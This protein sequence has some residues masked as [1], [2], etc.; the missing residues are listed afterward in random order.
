MGGRSTICLAQ[1][2][3]FFPYTQRW[4]ADG[5]RVQDDIPAGA[6]EGHGKGNDDQHDQPDDEPQRIFHSV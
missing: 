3:T 1:N 4:N 5:K 2:I 6:E